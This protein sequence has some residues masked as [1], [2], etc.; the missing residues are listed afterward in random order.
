MATTYDLFFTGRDDPRSCVII[1]EDVKPVFLCFETERQMDNMRTMVHRN[2]KDLVAYFEWSPGNHLGSAIIG[3]RRMPMS[4]FVQPGSYNNARSFLSANGNR[5]E[6]RRCPDSPTSYDLYSG[7]AVRIAA[8]R[9]YSQEIQT[10][11]GPS[12]AILQYTFTQELLLV[13]AL[14]ALCVNRCIDLYGI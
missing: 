5:F 1:G 9:R 4:H 2:N 10:A 14:L 11:V 6:W 12:H 3:T 7:P 8:F 13:E